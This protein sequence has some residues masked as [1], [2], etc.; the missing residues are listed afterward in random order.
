MVR[1]KRRNR[2]NERGQGMDEKSRYE[3]FNELTF[4]AYCKKAI[5]RAILKAR[6]RQSMLAKREV[7]LSE[8]PENALYDVG[9]EDVNLERAEAERRIFHVRGIDIPVSDQQL[10]KALSCL[11]PRNR[12]IILLAYFAELT[13][14]EV[15]QKLKLSRSTVQRRRTS[16]LDK[17]REMLGHDE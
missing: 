17:L 2:A 10:A 9:A 4:E 3:R 11:L 1:H 14:E 13:D 5:D 6:Q 8:L 15:A 16:A 12:E 7:S